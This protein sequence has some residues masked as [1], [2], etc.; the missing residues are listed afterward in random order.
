MNE[1]I[2]I[3]KILE[4]DQLKELNDYI[5][6]LKFTDT[7][8]FGNDSADAKVDNSI[9]SS[10]GAGLEE[11]HKTT[12][13]Y[14][15]AMN[16]GLDEYK[17]RLVNMYSNYDYY[18]VPGGRSTKSWREAV[19]ILEFSVGQQYIPHHDTANNPDFPQY[20]RQIS[21]I[22][23]LNNDFENGGTWFTHMTVKPEPGYAL[24]FPSN[25]CYPHAGLPVTKGKKRVAVTWY[26][27]Q[28]LT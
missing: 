2:Q 21:V 10:K 19:G 28:E 14:H 15:E 9:R 23:Y 27:V 3:I 25:W 18:P 17:R 4:P 24:I 26:Y 8:V 20:H 12:L 6:T 13:M 22:T 5:D 11:N 7:T 16:K 1:L